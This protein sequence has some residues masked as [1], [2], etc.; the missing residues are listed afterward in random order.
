MADSQRRAQGKRIYP[1]TLH[2]KHSKTGMRAV[3]LPW[4]SVLTRCVMDALPETRTARRIQAAMPS[5]VVWLACF[6]DSGSGTRKTE[7]LV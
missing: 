5:G 6:S 4:W 1:L 2:A 7:P 3:L